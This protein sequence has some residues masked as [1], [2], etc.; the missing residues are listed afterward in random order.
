MRLLSSLIILTLCIVTVVRGWHIAGFAEARVRVADGRGDVEALRRW[1]GVPGLTTPAL[2]ALVARGGRVGSPE[3]LRAHIDDLAH[4]LSLR[5]LSSAD[6]LSLA[7]ARLEAEKPT[8]QV[9]AALT[10]SWLTGPNEAA[11]MWPRAV[12]GILH[13]EALSPDARDRVVTDLAGSVVGHAAS[14]EDLTLAGHLLSRQSIDNRAAIAQKLRA[15][16]VSDAELEKLG[17]PGSNG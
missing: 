9:E 14:A 2:A 6:W 13:W 7:A 1:V 11:I 8:P 16:G 3:A 15:A 4:L 5:P 17:L 10:M 12:F